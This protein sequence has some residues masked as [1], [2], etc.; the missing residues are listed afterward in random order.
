L[1]EKKKKMKKNWIWPG[2]ALGRAPPPARQLRRASRG[3]RRTSRRRLAGPASLAVASRLRLAGPAAPPSQAAWSR[4]KR[5][6]GSI[7]MS[8]DPDGERKRE[9]RKGNGKKRRRDKVVWDPRMWVKK[10]STAPREGYGRL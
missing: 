10:N 8:R 6:K 4:G 1:Y 9:R 2:P 7:A 3:P 5:R